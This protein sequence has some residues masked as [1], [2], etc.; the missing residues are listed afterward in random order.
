[1][2]KFLDTIKLKKFGGNKLN[3]AKMNG[4]S[5]YSGKKYDGENKK[6]LV[7]SILSFSYNFLAMFSS[8]I[9]L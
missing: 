7:T 1:M 3:V 6:M 9:Y 8:V 5:F 4:F 2:I